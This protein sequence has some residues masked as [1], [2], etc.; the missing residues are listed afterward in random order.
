MDVPSEEEE[1]DRND[2]VLKPS[3]IDAGLDKFAKNMPIFEPERGDFSN[4]AQ[5]KPLAVNLDL[6]LYKARVLARKF[7]YDEAENILK[8]VKGR[9]IEFFVYTCIFKL[10]L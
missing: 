8:K 1:D 10:E 9:L 2:G 6:V 7:R 4:G 3:G 5:E